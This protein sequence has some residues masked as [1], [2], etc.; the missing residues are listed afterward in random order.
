[1]LLALIFFNYISQPN[2]INLTIIKKKF[3]IDQKKVKIWEL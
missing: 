3:L 1:M 2:F